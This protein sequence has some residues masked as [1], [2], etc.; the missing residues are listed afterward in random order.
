MMNKTL[1]IFVLG[2]V[3][4]LNFV[5]NAQTA[6]QKAWLIENSARIKKIED[7]KR[8]EAESLATIY[9]MPISATLSNGALIQLQSFENGMPYYHMTDNINAAAT[10]STRYVWENGAGGFSLSGNNQVIGLWEA[11]NGIPLLTHQE[12]VGRVAQRDAGGTYTD[13]ATHVAGT[14]IATGV[15]PN[16]RGMS[17]MARI[18]AYTSSGDL[19][20]IMNAA[21]NGLKV[22]NHSYGSIRGWVYDYRNDG[23]WAWFGT[24]AISETEDY[25]FGFYSS[26]S[27][28]WDYFMVNAP[29]ILVCKSAGNDRGDGPTSGTAHWV[30]INNN[31]VWSS[32]VRD[33]D[34]GIDG[35]DCINDGVGIS[36]NA[37]TVGAVNDIVNGYNSPSDVVVTS[38]SN[39]GPTD[40]GR[41]KPDIVANGTDLYSSTNTSNTAYENMSGTSMSSPNVAGSVALILEQQATLNGVTNAL[42]SSTVKG[43]IIHTADEAGT[44]P[45][46]DYRFGWGLL[47]TYKAVQLLTLDNEI[48][49]NQLIRELTLN[50]GGNEVF[51]VESN[52]TE[53][54]K[55]TICW[56]DPAG[57]PPQASLN[58]PNLML[59]N[60]LDLTVTGPNSTVYYPWVLDPSNPSAAATTGNNFRDNVEQVLIESPVAG[61]YT[62]KVGHK[63]NLTTGSQKFS[64]IISGTVVPVPDIVTLVEPVNNAQGV[65]SIQ[66]SCKWTRA[67]KSMRYELQMSL[68]STFN[69]GVTSMLSKTVTASLTNLPELAVVFWRVRAINSGGIGAWSAVNKFTTTYSL[70]SPPTLISP[71]NN[72]VHQNID[73]EFKWEDVSNATEYGFQLSNNVPF[74]D[75]IIDTTL[76]TNSFNFNN[77]QEGKK[78]YWRVSSINPSGTSAYSSKSNFT[79]KLKGP[80]T[81]TVTVN[82]NE[83]VVLNWTD[84][85]SVE[86]N[87]II[88]RKTESSNYNKLDSL[89]AN[90]TSYTDTSAQSGIG[91]HYAVYCKNNTASSD[92]VESA[93][94]VVSVEK[95]EDNVPTEYSLKQ[96][97]PNPFNPNTQIK[98]SVAKDGFVNLAVF[99]LLGQKVATLVSENQKAGN[100]EVNFNAAA[101]PSGVYFYS[102][103]AGDFKS[104]RKMILMK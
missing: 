80:D 50:Q 67:P 44:A 6:E 15:V 97:Y 68:D 99:N 23:K 102:L 71:P 39:E 52:G 78:L 84:K 31:W 9:Q 56:I 104:V 13:H 25:L 51:T 1:T 47:N 72:S 103:E 95:E 35:Y 63:N 65:S 29:N 100:Y 4:F 8:A 46:P 42:R 28:S 20:E 62:I 37:L 33:K 24:P 81:L 94:I 2:L 45:G 85:S 40:D 92:T 82:L 30:M 86:T 66:V 22:S 43:L 69:T 7:L 14:L 77:L 70:P 16:A 93:L 61:T 57:T 53:P 36:K 17:K 3:L 90:Q 60:D 27:A 87:Y 38:W 98:Y 54:L 83:D 79:T 41:I 101:L 96:N 75:I 12:L 88:L 26:T 48:G 91:Y 18:D 21:A 59:V 19:S 49:G 5:T 32:T 10:V 76:A 64:I 55:V 11:G 89:G 74:T 58:P 73:Q 34:G